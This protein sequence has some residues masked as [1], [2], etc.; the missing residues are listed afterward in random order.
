MSLQLFLKEKRKIDVG[1]G[2]GE[3]STTLSRERWEGRNLYE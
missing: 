2:K 1:A 3:V